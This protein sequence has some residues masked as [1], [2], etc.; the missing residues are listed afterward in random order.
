M[1]FTVHHIGH[2]VTADHKSVIEIVHPAKGL[3]ACR[4]HAVNMEPVFDQQI[5]DAFRVFRLWQNH[6]DVKHTLTPFLSPRKHTLFHFSRQHTTQSLKPIQVLIDLPIR[7][8][9]AVAVP[10]LFFLCNVFRENMLS[11]RVLHKRILFH[12]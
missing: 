4:T 5:A 11:Q 2:P 8:L 1:K 12:A 6:Y 7:N 10:L 9:T 3:R